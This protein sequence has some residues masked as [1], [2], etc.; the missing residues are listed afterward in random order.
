MA[1]SSPGV[2]VGT[3]PSVKPFQLQPNNTG[4]PDNLKTGIENLSGFSMNDVKVH[5]NSSK[6]A[7]LQALAYTQG[8]NIHVAPGQERHVPHEAWHV[9]QQKQQRV[10][11]T[12]QMKSAGIN[13]D[14]GLEREADIMGERAATGAPAATSQLKH[15]DVTGNYNRYETAPIQRKEA[16]DIPVD[17][18]GKPLK[19]GEKFFIPQG[20]VMTGITFVE[21]TF[22]GR[23]GGKLMGLF[24]FKVAGETGTRQLVG[25]SEVKELEVSEKPNEEGGSYFQET[26][27]AADRARK[28]YDAIRSKYSATELVEREAFLA[29]V[30]EACKED[31]DEKQVQQ[32]I[33]FLR[34]AGYLFP[35]FPGPRVTSVKKFSLSNEHTE[36]SGS[37]EADK[38]LTRYIEGLIS[39]YSVKGRN[40]HDQVQNAIIQ[41][42]LSDPGNEEWAAHRTKLIALF[43]VG[44]A[45]KYYTDTYV[46]AGDEHEQL[47]TCMTVDQVLYD[48]EH[49]TKLTPTVSGT[50]LTHLDY[51]RLTNVATQ[52]I[53]LKTTTQHS[54]NKNKHSQNHH[55]TSKKLISFVDEE[56]SEKLHG[57]PGSGRGGSPD[58]HDQLAKKI[59]S[60]ADLKEL[61]REL[62]AVNVD[63]LAGR[64]DILSI[65]AS[66]RVKQIYQ[67][68]DG[69][70]LHF[71]KERDLHV[72]ARNVE[73][74]RRKSVGAV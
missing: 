25:G 17:K 70:I 60:A 7:Q 32:A 59:G 65:P 29:Y 48:L 22:I 45:A 61:N 16:R 54:E 67:Q 8:S 40:K 35:A 42:I 52:Y 63:N 41:V 58:Y 1:T 15:V 12:L 50:K 37:G 39:T 38:S 9:V 46:R 73:V 56:D 49:P 21:A 6:P 36:E 74:R 34:K 28:L 2:N 26:G 66:K 33:L 4:L 51:Q 23:E 11:P 47:I 68:T 3:G 69:K 62:A 53:V 14:A 30:T 5:Y 44:T 24:F 10:Q 18:D 64:F 31:L 13:D 57:S 19:E 43:K 71:N 72:I 27:A 20:S 55:P